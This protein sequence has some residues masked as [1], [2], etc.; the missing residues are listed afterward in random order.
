MKKYRTQ[1]P[2]TKPKKVKTKYPIQPMGAIDKFEFASKL[3]ECRRALAEQRDSDERHTYTLANLHRYTFT[4]EQIAQI[5]V[6]AQVIKEHEAWV[7]YLMGWEEALD[8]LKKAVLDNKGWE[9][10]GSFWFVADGRF[11]R[12]RFKRA[13]TSVDPI[14]HFAPQESTTD[15]GTWLLECKLKP[16]VY[17]WLDIPESGLEII[18]HL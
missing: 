6:D 17:E 3:G 2:K 11:E 10:D 9:F 18:I 1:I 5:K 12:D 16:L 13:I 8:C 14:E 15:E 4:D 7:E